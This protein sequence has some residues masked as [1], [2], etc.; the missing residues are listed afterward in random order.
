MLR[1]HSGAAEEDNCSYHLLSYHGR[2]Y[3]IKFYHDCLNMNY[4]HIEVTI[5]WHLQ[6][7]Q[8]A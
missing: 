4:Y 8:P 1:P 3:D 7:N 6:Y 5:L 2:I